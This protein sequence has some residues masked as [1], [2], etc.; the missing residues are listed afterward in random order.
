MN[1]I[2]LVVADMTAATAFYTRLGVEFT[3]DGDSPTHA[4]CQLSSGVRL[5]LDTEEFVAT[6]TP[7]W[8]RPSGGP[9]VALA[10]Q[11][12]TPAGVDAKHAELTGAGYRSHTDPWD[13][14]WGM[15]YASV[16]DPDGNAIDLY[17]IL[18]S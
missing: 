11:F 7:G 10:F 1:A 3:V 8:V 9:R 4:D 12:D 17:A 5:M 15:R 16:L 18:P 2:G 6:H 14:D 13:A